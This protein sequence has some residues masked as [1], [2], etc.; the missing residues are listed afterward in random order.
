MIVV[1]HLDWVA[2]IKAVWPWTSDL[3]GDAPQDRREETVSSDAVRA[4]AISGVIPFFVSG[5]K[6]TVIIMV[7]D[8][9][10]ND[11]VEDLLLT[12]WVEI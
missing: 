10:D 6:E 9:Y 3:S 2:Q 8:D 4:A 11:F 12:R 5:C 7:I 1:K